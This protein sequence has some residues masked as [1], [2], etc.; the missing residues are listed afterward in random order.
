MADK[1]YPTEAERRSARID[2]L[3]AND[4]ILWRRFAKWG[5]E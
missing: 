3:L 2:Y 4:P 1:S 5:E